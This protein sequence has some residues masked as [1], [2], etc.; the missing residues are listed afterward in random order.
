ME[1]VST[2]LNVASSVE[3]LVQS[4]CRFL[5]VICNRG[6]IGLPKDESKTSPCR[7]KESK[8][9]DCKKQRIR[10]SGLQELSVTG[11]RREVRE[12][13]ERYSFPGSFVIDLQDRCLGDSVQSK[14]NKRPIPLGIGDLV[15]APG[16]GGEYQSKRG[17][18]TPCRGVKQCVKCGEYWT[19]MDQEH[20]IKLR[21]RSVGEA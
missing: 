7:R 3:L 6:R 11:R 2:F 4:C 20:H 12:S 18:G 10:S 15:D 1:G 21:E 13:H 14:F 19:K 9:M 17:L 8:V 5:S 16:G